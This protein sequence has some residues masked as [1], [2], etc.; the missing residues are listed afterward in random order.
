MLRR[1]PL[2][3]AG[4]ATRPR[5]SARRRDRC[6]QCGGV[7]GEDPVSEKTPGLK[8]RFKTLSRRCH[9]LRVWTLA[10]LRL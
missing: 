1:R 9:A 4:S 5:P 3:R 8:G 10:R 6:A 7:R 2:A